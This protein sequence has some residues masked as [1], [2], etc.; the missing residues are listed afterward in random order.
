MMIHSSSL[1]YT[2][3]TPVLVGNKVWTIS[4]LFSGEYVLKNGDDI[5]FSDDRGYY[6]INE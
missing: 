5:I 1:D 4:Y 3:L 2:D 6:N